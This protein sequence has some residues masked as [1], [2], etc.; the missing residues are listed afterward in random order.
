MKCVLS[1]QVVVAGQSMASSYTTKTLDCEQADVAGF[2]INFTGSPVGSFSVGGSQDGTNFATLP[3][4]V[5]GSVVTSIA[6]PANT[7]P[8]LIDLVTNSISYLQVV[9]TASSGTG[10]MTIYQTKKRVGD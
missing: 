9:Y 1:P 4:A 5:N 10:S 6:V 3:L 7:S 8:I 2:Q